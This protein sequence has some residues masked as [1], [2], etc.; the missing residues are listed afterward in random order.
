MAQS[1][2]DSLFSFEEELL[3]CIEKLQNTLTTKKLAPQAE[4]KSVL[5]LA[6]L[7]NKKAP[8]VK[9]RQVM[10]TACGDYR[11]EMKEDLKKSKHVFFRC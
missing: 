1:S 3:Y 6:T 10:R 8:F 5:A 7:I 11:K 2:E 4:K 9:K